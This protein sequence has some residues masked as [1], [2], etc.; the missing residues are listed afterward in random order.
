[1]PGGE[2]YSYAILQAVPNADRGE[3]INVGVILFCRRLDY[4]GF[5]WEVQVARLT[6]LDASA[7]GNML[8]Q[9]LTTLERIAEGDAAVGDLAR[10]EASERFHWIV[11]PS[12]T[13]I[14]SG[15]VHTGITS[16]PQATLDDLF[17]AL[18]R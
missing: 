7:D 15:P 1:M 17:R 14:V 11:A 5:R 10:L 9:H 4:L 6:A 16:D 12:S 18:V 8:T 2:A 3:R 13:A